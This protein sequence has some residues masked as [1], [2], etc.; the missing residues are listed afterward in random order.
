MQENTHSHSWFEILQNN[1]PKIHFPKMFYLISNEKKTKNCRNTFWCWRLK[2][3]SYIVRRPKNLKNAFHFVL[4]S[5]SD[6]KTK[7][8]FLW[9]DKIWALGYL[10]H[11]NFLGFR[12][13]LAIPFLFAIIIT[14]GEKYLSFW[15]LFCSY[16]KAGYMQCI[17]N[18]HYI[19]YKSK[20]LVQFFCLAEL[21]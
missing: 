11:L 9:P 16:T 4:T 20:L 6:V 7:R 18:L 14:P 10:S 21:V 8:K 5:L 3:S 19:N 12:Q 1:W 17:L 13:G 2:W 15:K